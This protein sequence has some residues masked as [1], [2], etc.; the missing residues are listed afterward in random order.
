MERSILAAYPHT[1]IWE[2]VQTTEVAKRRMAKW[3]V[4]CPSVASDAKVTD[5][6]GVCEHN[7]LRP[8]PLRKQISLNSTAHFVV[9]T[10]LRDSKHFNF[11]FCLSDP[12]WSFVMSLPCSC[13]DEARHLHSPYNRGTMV[14]G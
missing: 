13:T 11:T 6:L 7:K 8:P 1:G 9:C 3:L 14:D 4:E 12:Y 10:F 2:S 5:R